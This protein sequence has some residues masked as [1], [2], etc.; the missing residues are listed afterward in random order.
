MAGR[1][2]LPQQRWNRNAHPWA[3]RVPS[4]DG[5]GYFC[6]VKPASHIPLTERFTSLLVGNGE[7]RIVL[8]SFLYLPTFLCP[9]TSPLLFTTCSS[10]VSRPE[11]LFPSYSVAHP[12]LVNNQREWERADCPNHSWWRK[13][14]QTTTHSSLRTA[15]LGKQG[16]GDAAVH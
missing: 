12:Q 7:S 11:D 6:V 2:S 3:E 16:R 14:C 5:D 9:P 15:T 10:G 4:P 8:C 13:F 1:V